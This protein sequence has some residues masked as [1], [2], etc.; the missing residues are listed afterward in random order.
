VYFV[1]IVFVW[2]VDFWLVFTLYILNLLIANNS[3]TLGQRYF[4]VC[5]L[6]LNLFSL[7]FIGTAHYLLYRGGLRRNWGALN[8]SISAR[9]GFGKIQ[10]DER[11][12]ALKIFTS[13]KKH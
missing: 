5:A 11:R 7:F 2:S 10:R 3:V 8:F 9:G 12:G 1:F 6:R 4:C 13:L